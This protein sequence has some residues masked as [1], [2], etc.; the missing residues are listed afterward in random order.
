MLGSPIVSDKQDKCK[1]IAIY[2]PMT[3]SLKVV[4]ELVR[5]LLK[6]FKNLNVL[7]SY[8]TKNK[9]WRN[10]HAKNI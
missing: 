8:A 3:R 1:D 4:T 7:S 9:K 10:Y 2:Q 5:W 6:A